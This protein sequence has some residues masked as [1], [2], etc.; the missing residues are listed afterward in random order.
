MKVYI[1]V[2]IAVFFLACKKNSKEVALKQNNPLVAERLKPCEDSHS[3]YKEALLNPEQVCDLFLTNRDELPKD[4]SVF[5][6]LRYLTLHNCTIDSFPND[7]VKK[8]DL[9]T[10]SISGTS[11][12]PTQI[13]LLKKLEELIILKTN[14]PNLEDKICNISGLSTLFLVESIETADSL[15]DCISSFDRLKILYIGMS[16]I[17]KLPEGF[18]ELTQLEELVI[19]NTQLETIQYHLSEMK[20]L[21]KLHLEDNKLSA[22]EIS[23]LKEKYKGIDLLIKQK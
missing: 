16:S 19:M 15:S 22:K 18:A 4:I 6:N 11:V 21:K 10:L 20:N 14:I 1:Y 8:S 5:T 23:F 17:T 9:K 3:S 13:N 12:L 2:L 7:F